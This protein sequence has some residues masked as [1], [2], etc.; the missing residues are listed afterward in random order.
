MYDGGNAIDPAN[1]IQYTC[2][3]NRTYTFNT[4]ITSTVQCKRE[5]Q[6][7]FTD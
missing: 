4:E 6:N 3:W 5:H 2:Q 7:H 1:P